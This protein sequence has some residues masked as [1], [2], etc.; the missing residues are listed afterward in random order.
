MLDILSIVSL[1]IIVF[2][3]IY[4]KKTDDGKIQFDLLQD[5]LKG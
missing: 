2:I 3:Y 4:T 1:S 5:R